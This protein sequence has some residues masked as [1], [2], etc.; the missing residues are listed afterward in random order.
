MTFTG[1]FKL[2]MAQFKITPPSL[3]GFGTDDESK[4]ECK[5]ACQ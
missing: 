5:V 3:M 1:D 4:L 2:K